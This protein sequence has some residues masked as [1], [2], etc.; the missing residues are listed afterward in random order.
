MSL[1]PANR[2]HPLASLA[3]LCISDPNVKHE[4][5]E[6]DYCTHTIIRVPSTHTRGT[7]R[8]EPRVNTAR[9]DSTSHNNL[10]QHLYLWIDDLINRSRL[11]LSN[12]KHALVD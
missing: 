5:L 4:I 8:N 12:K 6:I 3:N 7:A 9:I 11:R 1:A 10:T 2:E